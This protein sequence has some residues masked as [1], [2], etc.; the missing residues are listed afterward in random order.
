[1]TPIPDNLNTMGRICMSIGDDDLCSTCK[2]LI[3]NPGELSVCVHPDGDDN[4]A[5][6]GQLDGGGTVVKCSCFGECLPGANLLTVTR[7]TDRYESALAYV[8]TDGTA[9]TFRPVDMHRI[10]TLED[11]YGPDAALSRE[12]IPG[13]LEWLRCQMD[14]SVV[15]RCVEI[16]EAN[17]EDCAVKTVDTLG[18]GGQS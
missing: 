2:H 12:E 8:T 18:V 9:D 3:Y 11:V 1:M 6:P 7:S 16:F 13:F 17:S 14:E 5:W 4:E 10:L 15:D